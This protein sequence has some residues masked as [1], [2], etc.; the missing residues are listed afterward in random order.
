MSFTTSRTP[1]GTLLR[2]LPGPLQRVVT[3][4]IERAGDTEPE[5]VGADV[6]RSLGGVGT[7]VSRPLGVSSVGKDAIHRSLPL[8]WL[9]FLTLLCAVALFITAYAFTDARNGGASIN[10]LFLPALL[11]MFTPIAV[12]LLV[13]TTPRAE[14]IWLLCMV[15]LGCYLV[16]VL[17][18]PLYFSFFD[19]FL[20][21]RTVD[22][23][24]RS[25]HLFTP[26]ALLPVS[27]YY[28]GLEI[29]TNAFSTISGLSS[30]NAGLVVIGMS[31]LLMVLSLFALNEQVLKSARVASLATLL[32]MIN[33]H[34][35]LF[36]AQYGYESLALPLATLMLFALSPHQPVSVRLTRLEP[37][38]S[39]VRFSRIGRNELHH[40]LRWITLTAWLVLV[41][42]VLTH[43]VTDFFFDALLILWTIVYAWKRLTPFYRSKLVLT[44]GIGVALALASVLQIGNPVVSYLSSFMS[45]ALDEL[46][47]ILTGTGSAKQLFVNYSG[48][49]TPIWERLITISSVGI[50]VFCLPFGLLC[51]VKRY[52]SNAL[53]CTFGF[54][55]LLYPVSQAFR[56]TNSGAEVA[57]RAAAFLFIP[58][59][60]VLAIFIAQ[61]WP[62]ARL[63]W[64]QTTLIV[65]A[66]SLVFIGGVVLGAG[67]ASALL[68][69]PYEVIADSRSIEPEG[70]QAALWTHTYLQPNSRVASDRI[71][72]VLLGTY[73]DQH[74]VTSIED[75]I[76]L[77]PVFLSTSMNDE[78]KALL[79]QAQVHYLVTDMRLTHSLP[80]LGYYYEMDE[81]DAFHRKTPIDE[82]AFTKFSTAAQVN[83]V[84]DGGNIV[85]YDVGGLSRALEK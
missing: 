30:F 65:S 11:L 26:N 10:T 47:H 67:P 61:F 12:R 41:A 18:T 66:M 17:A 29:V 49:P 53:A 15:G 23:I 27:P 54:L 50:I 35:L 62:I 42:V 58:I 79:Q 40:D 76:D 25:G 7:D 21:W 59:A 80:L 31:R 56:L 34:F 38:A 63:R 73:G 36:D 9:S 37:L 46:G 51:L 68:P 64:G 82:Q 5:S 28:S 13:P 71:N 8:G 85:I 84:Y 81:A 3:K 22:D 60:S 14:R 55:S 16:K 1:Y 45:V 48:P 39:M 57:D 4:T 78:D 83:R 20:H 75:N 2:V 33:P 44:A 69:G 52:R 72:Q 32:Y 77:S 43:H 74:V 19:E 70:I 24:A 6:S